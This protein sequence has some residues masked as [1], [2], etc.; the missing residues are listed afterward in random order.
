MRF[1]SFVGY[2]GVN[3]DTSPKA[4]IISQTK[5]KQS[6]GSEW[7]FSRKKVALV[8][9]NQP[10]DT[11]DTRVAGWIPG[12]EDPLEQE[13]VTHPSILAWRITWTEEPGRCTPWDHK[14][15]DTTEQLTQTQI[16]RQKVFIYK[17]Q[18]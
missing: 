13:M 6:L 12:W 15:L 2:M 10:A 9:N 18:F 5:S 7:S 8:V 17:I 4:E 1:H 16:I 14:E 11:G 3:P